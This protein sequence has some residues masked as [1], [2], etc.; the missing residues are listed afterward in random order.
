MLKMYFKE[1]NLDILGYPLNDSDPRMNIE[2]ISNHIDEIEAILP[3][4]EYS[5]REGLSKLNEKYN[6]DVD[7]DNLLEK[8]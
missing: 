1:N 8:L 7:Y 3:E 2:W 5:I 6:L 4:K